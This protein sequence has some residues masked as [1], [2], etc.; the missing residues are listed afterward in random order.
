[1]DIV[2]V[3]YNVT[4]EGVKYMW[5]RASLIKHNN[6]L[7]QVVRYKMKWDLGYDIDLEYGVE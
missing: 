7:V 1:M 2:K 5:Y 3:K 6:K 4:E